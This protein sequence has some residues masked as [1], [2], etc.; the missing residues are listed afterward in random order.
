LKERRYGPSS[1]KAVTTVGDICPNLLATA[2]VL[3]GQPA[4]GRFQSRRSPALVL[5]QVSGTYPRDSR[6]SLRHR[7]RPEPPFRCGPVD[8]VGRR[9]LGFGAT[10]GNGQPPPDFKTEHYPPAVAARRRR[11][12]ERIKDMDLEVVNV[13]PTLASGWFGTWTAGDDVVLAMAWNRAD[14]RWMADYCRTYPN[15]LGG[16]ILTGARDIVGRRTRYRRRACRN[17]PLGPSRLGLGHLDGT[18]RR[19]RRD[20]QGGLARTRAQAERVRYRRTLFPQHRDPRG[21]QAGQCGHRSGRRSRADVRVGLSAWREP[22]PQSASLV[23]DWAMD[24]ERKRKL[25]WDNAVRF[26]ARARSK[27]KTQSARLSQ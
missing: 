2:S 9:M 24:P 15:R 10:L 3:P 17:S 13:N 4:C 7:T 18:G 22:F 25:L 19:A 12:S 26:Y 11:S 27:V 16:V 5:R 21:C 23:L 20:D 14:H 8:G 1:V 6:S